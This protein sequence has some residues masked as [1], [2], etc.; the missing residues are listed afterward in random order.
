MKRKS[1]AGLIAIA[2]INIGA[3]TT[4]WTQLQKPLIAHMTAL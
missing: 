2:A 3:L 1:I 4:K